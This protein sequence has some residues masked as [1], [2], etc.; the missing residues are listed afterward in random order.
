MIPGHRTRR[1][2]VSAKA[3]SRDV[4]KNRYITSV[5]R[6]AP[7]RASRD[8]PAAFQRVIEIGRGWPRVEAATRYDGSPQ[9]KVNGCF[10]AGLAMGQDAEPDTLVIRMN[11][12]DRQAM[13]EDAPDIYYT[14]DYHRR[15]P[16]VLVRLAKVDDEMLRE[17]LAISRRL[18]LLKTKS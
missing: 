2:E 13:I 18:T 14:T 15:F 6:R 9:L 8:I 1:V 12:D 16:V 3:R 5:P 4:R 10:M 17:L 11:A 7:Q